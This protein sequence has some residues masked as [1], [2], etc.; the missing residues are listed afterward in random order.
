[1]SDVQQQPERQYLPHQF[2]PGHEKIPGSGRRPGQQARYT[3]L[4]KEAV[5]EAAELEGSDGEG[6]DGLI[7]L[8]RRIAKEDIKTFAMLLARAMPLQ[9]EGRNDVRVEVMYDSVEEVRDE[10]AARGISM[11]FVKQLMF[12]PAEEV[13]IN[14]EDPLK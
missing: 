9:I 5:M 14:N 8:L 7:G 13:V 3:R 2:K 12:A 10:L 11:E 1:M 6:K 4:L